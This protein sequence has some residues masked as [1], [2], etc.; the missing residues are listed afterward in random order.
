MTSDRLLDPETIRREIAAAHDIVIAE[1][2]SEDEGVDSAARSYRATATDGSGWFVK[3]RRD[4]RPA[5]IL[6]P[7]F[8]A[9]S[10]L[11]EVVASVPPR[12]G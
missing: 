2:T 11:P 6:V 12:S 4:V 5:A 3:V 10:G 8:L 9:A 1:L 7:R